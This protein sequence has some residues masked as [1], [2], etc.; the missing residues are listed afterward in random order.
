MHEILTFLSNPGNQTFVEE[1][2]GA[3]LFLIG[4]IVYLRLLTKD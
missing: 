2:G 4:F 1:A 3:V